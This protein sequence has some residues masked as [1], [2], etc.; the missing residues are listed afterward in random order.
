MQATSQ[1]RP[2]VL[3]GILLIVA[4]ADDPAGEQD[5]PRRLGAEFTELFH[6]GDDPTEHQFSMIAGMAFAPDGRLVVV[7]GQGFNVTV[8]DDDG[9]LTARWGREGEGPGE[10]PDPPDELA[11]S[12]N[13]T[14]A[15]ETFTRV[16]LFT[17]D[18]SFV[19]SRVVRPFRITKFAFHAGEAMVATADRGSISRDLPQELVRFEDGEVLWTSPPLPSIAGDSPI[20]MWQGRPRFLPLWD[21]RVAVGM[22]DAYDLQV[23]EVAT[24]RTI[25]QISRIVP[26]RGPTDDWTL[27]H[28]DLFDGDTYEYIGTVEIPEGLILMAGDATRIAGFQR[29]AFD[30]QSVRVLR[31]EI[32]GQP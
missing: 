6:V 24:G 9:N 5:G 10:F 2:L 8:H 18:G 14:V 32:E 23:L 3:A 15:I 4:C 31:V 21:G 13:G 29:G 26:L 1:A 25:D 27:R 28:Y 30:V 11:I 16:D 12:E 19:N 17:L 20:S 7:D 22:S